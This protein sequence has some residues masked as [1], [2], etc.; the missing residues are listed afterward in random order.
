MCNKR[1][2]LQLSHTLRSPFFGMRTIK[3]THTHTHTNSHTPCRVAL[4]KVVLSGSVN[5]L[6][7]GKRQYYWWGRWPESMCNQSWVVSLSR[8][9]TLLTSSI[10]TCYCQAKKPK[11]KQNTVFDTES[12]VGQ[13]QYDRHSNT[14]AILP[15][16]ENIQDITSKQKGKTEK[17]PIVSQ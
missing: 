10:L 1:M 9:K 8:N 14:M 11:E 12:K 2:L 13:V 4:T 16:R 5:T 17:L 3:V 15:H 6:N 7:K